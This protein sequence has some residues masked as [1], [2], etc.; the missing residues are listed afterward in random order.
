[1]WMLDGMWGMHDGGTG[2]W[3]FGAVWM[4]V[5]WGLIIGLIV[6]AVS[7]VTGERGRGETSPLDIARTRYARGELTRDEFTQIKRDLESL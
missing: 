1:M 3:V 2:W 7:R 5:F 6:W 4:V